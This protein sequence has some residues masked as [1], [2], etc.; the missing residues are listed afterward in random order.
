MG[1]TR[2][3]YLTCSHIKFLISGHHEFVIEEN[4]NKIRGVEWFMINK[5]MSRILMWV[6]L[7]RRRMKKWL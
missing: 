1:Y 3:I 5:I 4:D 6:W 7:I 2:L